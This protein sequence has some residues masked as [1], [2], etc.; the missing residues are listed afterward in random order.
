MGN[1]TFPS[2]RY[3]P[4]GRSAIFRSAEEVPEGWQD[5]P[6]RVVESKTEEPKPRGRPKKVVESEAEPDVETDMF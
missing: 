5:H 3:G 4:G 2:F 1:Q 6:S